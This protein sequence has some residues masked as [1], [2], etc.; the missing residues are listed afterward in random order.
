MNREYHKWYSPALGRDM[1]LLI[2]GHAGTPILFFPTRT[3]RFYDYENWKIINAISDKINKGW[4]QVYCVDS[5]DIESFYNKKIHPSQRIQRHMQ[6]ERYILQ[7]VLPLM[8]YKNPNRYITAAGCSLGGYHAINIALKN[9]T[10][11]A[12]A[13]GM[14]GRY[15]LTLAAKNFPDLFDGYRDENTYFNMPT[16]YIANLTDHTLLERLRK[17]HI[18][19]AVGKE[20]PFLHNNKY[21][22][23]Q[24]LSKGVPNEIH[25]WNGEAHRACHWKEMVRCYL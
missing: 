2:F 13:V 20:D 17:M 15:D 10:Q 14:S 21:L 7:E 25:L 6:Y 22:H 1:E 5:I 8:W 9:P 11:F 23:W 12:K 18:I 19:F 4:L 16:Q 24:L 3:A